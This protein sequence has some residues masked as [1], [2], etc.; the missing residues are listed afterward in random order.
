MTKRSTLRVAP[1]SEGVSIWSGEL[2]GAAEAPR[3]RDFLVR[4]FS[5]EEVEQVEWRRSAAFGRIRYGAT[6]NPALIWKKLSRAL[7]RQPDDAV[8]VARR[9]DAN[10]LC[11]DAPGSSR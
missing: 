2:F 7:Q 4:A 9:L 10:A 6:R 11:L 8:P 1:G 3:L 5:V